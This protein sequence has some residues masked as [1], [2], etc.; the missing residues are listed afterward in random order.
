MTPRVYTPEQVALG[1][2]VIMEEIDRQECRL[3]LY[4]DGQLVM[5][6][7]VAKD[8][9]MKALIET[10]KRP[11]FKQAIIEAARLVPVPRVGP[12]LEA[13][14]EVIDWKKRTIAQCDEEDEV[15]QPEVPSGAAIV[16]MDGDGRTDSWGKDMG[17][18]AY[19]C[20]RGS[21][22]GW[23]DVNYFP[24]PKEYKGRLEENQKPVVKKRQSSGLD[25]ERQS[26]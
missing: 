1:V 4:D 5:S 14:Q 10:I 7:P 19:W 13:T 11:R 22:K 18:V 2:D 20:W 25:F 8:D 6:G 24:V 17:R 9:A 3:K 15:V 26:K 23:F 16:V 12:K 21:G